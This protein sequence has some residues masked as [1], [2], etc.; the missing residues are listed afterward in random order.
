LRKRS[1]FMAKENEAAATRDKPQT[2]G[3]I[4]VSFFGDRPPGQP[5][6][7]LRLSR[8]A[9]L[10]LLAL[11]VILWLTIVNFGLILE[12]AGLLFGALLLAI[13]LKPIVDRLQRWRIPR[14]LGVGLAYIV[15]LG[16]LLSMGALLIP[17]FTSEINTLQE[18]GPILVKTVS[19]HIGQIPILKDLLPAQDTVAQAL[20]QRIDSI[21]QT[22]FQTVS[23]VGNLGLDLLVLMILA[24]IFAV[25]P[26]VWE[27]F[28]LLWIPAPQKANVQRIGGGVAWQLRRWIWAQP[29]VALYLG[30]GFSLTL[31]LLHIPFAFAIGLVGGVFGII[32]FVGGFFAMALAV[33][34][35]LTV[36]PIMALWVVLIF[37]L[38]LEIQAHIMAPALFGRALH[39]HPGLIL[40]ALVVGAKAGG[41][42]GIFLSVPLAVVFMI[43]LKE[44]RSSWV[45]SDE[46]PE[47]RVSSVT[48]KRSQQDGKLSI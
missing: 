29:L 1:V 4:P 3:P 20:S 23:S 46:D 6:G 28:I 9:W 16:L 48:G 30:I 32:P 15:L 5:S 17:L 8:Q 24:Y 18:Q 35:A 19:D 27:R 25:T 22:I 34:S 42:V 41:L 36:N 40:V 14:S 33:L 26:D 31:T 11:G 45:I 7:S 43:L 38:L 13:G 37:A 12:M 21:V 44:A 39:L 47:A 10:A 2:R